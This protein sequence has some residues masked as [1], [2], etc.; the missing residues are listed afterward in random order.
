MFEDSDF[1]RLH[2]GKLSYELRR[3]QRRGRH[4]EEG[5][6]VVVDGRF[7]E[8]YM[9][10]LAALL[11]R[12]IDMSP[13]TNEGPSAGVNLR[14]LIDDV[15]ASG[16]TASRGALVSVVME[17]LRVDP[18]TPIQKLLNFRR[19]RRDQLAELSGKFDA[20]KSSIEKSAD[21]E[22][23]ECRARRVFENEIRPALMKLKNELRDQAIGSA[24]EGF[25]T[26]ATF[27][28]APSAALWATGFSAPVALGVGAFITAAGIGIKSYLGQSEARA[29]SPYTYL[30]DIER[31]FS[32]PV[33]TTAA[34]G[35]GLR[36]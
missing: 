18:E 29:A 36:L 26:A 7:A 20:L 3:L 11:A 22:E 1:Y 10:A 4:H 14:C 31:K 17:G 9:S 27:S 24:W 13:L 19:G 5:D 33:I 16:P 30:M 15:S 35:A 2:P 8:I 32:V 28:A 6:W 21:G 23:I 34:S 12:E 25:Q